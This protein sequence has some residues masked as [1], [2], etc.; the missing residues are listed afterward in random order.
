MLF[1]AEQVQLQRPQNEIHYF[2]LV[3]S[4]MN[5]ASQLARSGAPHGTAVLADAQV[6]GIGRLGRSWIS[7]AGV[8][9][10]CSVLLRLS[11][12]PSQLPIGSL[13]IGLATADAI[14]QLTGLNCDLRWPNDVLIAERKV[15]GVLAQLVDHCVVAGIG[16]NVNQ[17]ALP[18]NLRTPATSLLLAANGRQWSR[19]QLTIHLLESLDVYCQLLVADGCDAVLRA[20]TAASSYVANRRVIVEENGLQGVT[21]GLDRNGFLLVRSDSGQLQRISSGGVRPVSEVA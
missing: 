12:P 10:Y 6:K 19:E 13:M 8:G 1:D 21:A 18:A 20:F 2:P 11:V 9:I 17:T 14:Q 16:I 15:A 4:T 5:H 3:D 7:E